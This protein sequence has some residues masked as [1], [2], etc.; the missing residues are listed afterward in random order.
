MLFLFL[1][2][3]YHTK[4]I[5]SKLPVAIFPSFGLKSGGTFKATINEYSSENLFIGLSVEEQVKQL[6]DSKFDY[7]K[8]CQPNSLNFSIFNKTIKIDH[9]SG[10]NIEQIIKHTSTVYPIF[11]MCEQSYMILNATITFK[12]PKNYLDLRLQMVYFCSILHGLLYLATFLICIFAILSKSAVFIK[13]HIYLITTIISL[14]VEKFAE[15]YF[16]TKNCHQPDLPY[17]YYIHYSLAILSTGL[18]FSSITLASGGWQIHT[19][20]F[21]LVSFLLSL[22]AGF[23]TAGTNIFP[24]AIIQMEPDLIS[25]FIQLISFLVFSKVSFSELRVCEQYL[26]SYLLI[27]DTVG[28]NSKTTP[29]HRRYRMQNILLGILFAYF[30]AQIFVLHIPLYLNH[31]QIWIVYL[32]KSSLNNLLVVGLTIVYL[33]WK[34]DRES[35]FAT[36]DDEDKL[37]DCAM[38]D[39]NPEAYTPVNNP[40]KWEAGDKLPLPPLIAATEY[41]IQSFD[42]S[43][44]EMP[45]IDKNI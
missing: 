14:A 1:L 38:E 19:V 41:R 27:I 22:F 2:S 16:Y 24:V 32:T 4:R 23:C 6:W 12:N 45:L 44:K 28:I 34:I 9:V 8:V 18:L 26:Q 21:S 29:V 43:D 15:F 37:A 31:L 17:F 35:W 10:N 20:R 30:L 7:T 11:I 39:F 33:P 25:Y 13:Y 5:N 40:S 3:Y 42:I 36:F